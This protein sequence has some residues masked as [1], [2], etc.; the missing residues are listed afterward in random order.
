MN[1]LSPADSKLRHARAGGLQ[2]GLTMIELM[3]A[4]TLGLFVVFSASL[5]LL[6][7]KTG[8]VVQDENLRVQE[9]GRFAIELIARALRQTAYENWES[10]A[11]AAVN[12]P[13]ISSNISG[14]DACSL[15]ESN[16]GID[17]P[18]TKSVNGSD[19]L[20][21]RFAG[22]GLSPNGDGSIF[23]CAGFGVAEPVDPEHDR[24]WSIFY[25]AAD[26]SGEPELRCKY[27]GKTAWNSEAI[28]RGV[29]AFQVLYGVDTD[30]DGAVNRYVN[31]S[32]IEELDGKLK[33]EG[34]NATERA[35]DRIRKTHWKK[36]AVV[37]VALLV[38][39]AQGARTGV[40]EG[41]YDL[42]GA[43]YAQAFAKR[44]IGTSIEERSLDSD[45]RNRIRKVFS[46]TIH[47]RS[48][49]Q[50]DST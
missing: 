11:G 34:H 4:M 48:A 22:A 21:V 32:G 12:S 23:N 50:G 1:H 24:G 17:F 29:E 5:L 10:Q 6:S 20:A 38:R 3:I 13:N 16:P 9:T 30:S 33:L 31:A 36:I 27:R 45:S 46:T 14:L 28:A 25:V 18:V 26:K 47:L 40:Q 15:K 19:V 8:Y 7:S 44:D 39:S 2:S 42:F 37:K 49:Q 35:A 41:R 43:S